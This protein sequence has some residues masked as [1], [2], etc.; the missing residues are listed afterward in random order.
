VKPIRTAVIVAVTVLVTACSTTN[1]RTGPPSSSSVPRSI[2]EAVA[3]PS[4]C[5]ELASAYD[6]WAPT[7]LDADLEPVDLPQLLD[8]GQEFA[9]QV[10]TVEDLPVLEL[11]GAVGT[12]TEELELLLTEY[13]NGEEPS[14]FEAELARAG[15][16]EQVQEITRASCG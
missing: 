9:D 14:T 5:A 16:V 4:G 3:P 1:D 7:A 13:E 11:A 12:Y 8:E 6:A 15:V 2:D 10:L